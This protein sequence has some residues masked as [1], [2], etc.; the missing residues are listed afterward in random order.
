MVD[1]VIL[2]L[3]NGEWNGKERLQEIVRS[4]RTIIATDGAWAK[5]HERGIKVDLVIGDADSL[6]EA[7]RILLCSSPVEVLTYPCEKDWTDLELAL[8][9]A[10]SRNPDRISIYGALGGRV[11]HSLASLFLLEKGVVA[12]VPIE[13]IAGDERIFLLADRCEVPDAQIGDR[14]SLLS[15]AETVKIK[16]TGLKYT[17]NNDPLRRASSKGISNEIISSPVRL[18]VKDGLALVIHAKCGF[19]GEEYR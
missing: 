5:A 7:E 4:A 2:I 11:D 19:R 13:I 17:L 3:A 14:I 8:D 18:E 12:K 6:T 16:T 10:L 15:L 9:N 1:N